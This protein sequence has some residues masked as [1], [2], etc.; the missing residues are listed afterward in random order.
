MR[1]FDGMRLPWLAPA[2][3]SA[4]GVYHAPATA[5]TDKTIGSQ[6][7]TR[8]TPATPGAPIVGCNELVAAHSKEANQMQVV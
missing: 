4:Q 2:E 7:G 1:G 5:K 6:M 8:P 3:M